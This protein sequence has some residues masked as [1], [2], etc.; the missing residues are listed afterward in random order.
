MGVEG[1]G[2]SFV[3]DGSHQ[4]YQSKARVV[5]SI[6]MESRDLLCCLLRMHGRQS[7]MGIDATQVQSKILLSVSVYE[8]P[9][10]PYPCV[11]TRLQIFC[12]LDLSKAE[13]KSQARR[14]TPRS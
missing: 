5:M 14:P 6:A 4:I 10:M 11:D 13:I 8:L 3:P 1:C 2:D 12:I 9:T 7:F